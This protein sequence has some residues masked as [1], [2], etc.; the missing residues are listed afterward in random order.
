MT[1]PIILRILLT[2]VLALASATQR[3]D[4]L[5]A[6]QANAAEESASADSS[7]ASAARPATQ[8]ARPPA[9][10]PAEQKL[11]DAGT[12]FR[13]A[14][15]PVAGGEIDW[16]R[17]HV[18]GTG[19]TKV[20]GRDEQAAAMARR[21]ARV[22]AIRNAALATRGIRIGPDGK[23]PKI[24]DGAI[25]A[26][27]IVK[28]AKELSA[29][30]DRAK[31][32]VTVRVAL[33]LHGTDGV[34]KAMGVV[35]VKPKN[36]HGGGAM[37]GGRFDAVVIDARGTGFRPCLA[38]RIASKSGAAILSA[39]DVPAA[40]IQQRSIVAYVSAPAPPEHAFGV[41]Q[42]TRQ[43]TAAAGRPEPKLRRAAHRA[44]KNPLLLKAESSPKN[45]PGTLV[46]T[47]VSVR[48]LLT[49]GPTRTLLKTTRIIVVTDHPLTNK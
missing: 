9:P 12:E 31:G 47:P 19:T 48:S 44:F 33:P 21:G 14:V 35:P 36:P 30:H 40:G 23:V 42:Q 5:K 28:G 10:T 11:I 1:R 39:G 18:I 43:I 13:R 34:V 22:L 8:P 41:I 37:A 3:A 49:A 6:S 29:D 17:G 20:A 26:D 25:A 2:G 24:K 7:K 32:T 38:P 45:S 16:T 15:E 27:M 4:P 46:L